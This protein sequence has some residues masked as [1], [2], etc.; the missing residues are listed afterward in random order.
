MATKPVNGQVGVKLFNERV[1]NL[2]YLLLGK[3]LR[4][5][6]HVCESE[7]A[8]TAANTAEAAGVSLAVAR[9]ILRCMMYSGMVRRYS[10]RDAQEGFLGRKPDLYTVSERVSRW[11]KNTKETFGE[12]T[13]GEA[14]EVRKRRNRS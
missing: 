7:E 12:D 14:V 11:W 9:E 2:F 1:T 6:A 3:R 8:V 5:F 13:D 10:Y 4:V